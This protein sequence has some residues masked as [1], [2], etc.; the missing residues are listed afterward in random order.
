[1]INAL[2]AASLPGVSEAEARR[3]LHF[4]LVGAGP[5]GCECAAELL[6]FMRSDGARD[7]P[8]VAHLTRVTLV[9]ALPRLLPMLPKSLSDV[10][11]DRFRLAGV[12]MRLRTGVT[13]VEPNVITMKNLDTNE[14]ERVPFGLC[15]WNTGNTFQDIFGKLIDRIAAQKGNRL[16]AVDQHLRVKGVNGVFAIGDCSRMAPDKLADKAA[17]IYSNVMAFGGSRQAV[18]DSLAELRYTYPQLAKSKWDATKCPPPSGTLT[19]ESLKEYLESIDNGY[20]PPVPTAQNAKYAGY[21]LASVFNNDLPRPTI[22][23]PTDWDSVPGFVEVWK[24]TLTYVG[25]GR[26]VAT[27]PWSTLQGGAGTRIFWKALYWSM[28]ST[29]PNR[30]GVAFDWLRVWLFGRD[31]IAQAISRTK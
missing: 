26:V 23:A 19:A 2:E 30:M 6:D 24:G 4:V 12:E 7:Y 16:L 31:A 28:Q 3:L 20:V 8:R 29:T 27:T 13:K 5:S 10:A 25:G 9:D 21:Y 15:V 18:L 14:E 22:D 17:D 1:M 11:M